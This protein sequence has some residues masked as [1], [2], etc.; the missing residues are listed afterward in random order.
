[1]K[2]KVVS[3]PRRLL[4]P[5]PQA[6]CTSLEIKNPLTAEESDWSLSDSTEEEETSEAQQ[7]VYA[8]EIVPPICI[9]QSARML[10]NV[11]RH[12][13]LVTPIAK[14]LR[15]SKNLSDSS[16]QKPD[17]LR[18]F[19]EQCRREEQGESVFWDD[20]RSVAGL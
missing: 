12:Q 19:L 2:R 6:S 9:E 16:N 5:G 14:K 8:L 3:S 11:D 4:Q 18:D 17:S 13:L 7:N 1:M 10:L 15:C 20:S